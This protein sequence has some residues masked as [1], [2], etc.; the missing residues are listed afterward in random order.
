M[1]QIRIRNWVDN[2]SRLTCMEDRFRFLPCGWGSHGKGPMLPK[3]PAHPGYRISQIT[4][5]PKVRSIGLITHP[6][7]CFDFDG[8]TSWTYARNTGI[9]DCES[10]VVARSTDPHRFKVLFAPTATQLEQLPNAQITHSRLTKP[11]VHDDN[12]TLASKGEALEVFCHPGRQVIVLGEHVESGG[13]YYWPEGRG[14]EQLA[15]PPQTW[16]DYVMEQA[17]DYPR[18]AKSQEAG[19]REGWVRLAKCPICG[20]GPRDNP[21]CQLTGDGQVLRCFVGSTF[22]PPKGL[23]PGQCV[24]GTDWAFVREDDVGWGRF[25]LYVNDYNPIRQ[26]RRW[27]RGQ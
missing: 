10:W 14:P 22:Y 13:H 25:N 4:S 3:W 19:S 6:L 23:A 24:S 17:A 9:E 8:E 7:L 16:W 12:G 27:F 21:V 20:R 15:P 26:A 2:S 5:T 18:S 1:A 11:A